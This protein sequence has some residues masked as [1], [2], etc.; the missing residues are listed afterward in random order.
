MVSWRFSDFISLPNYFFNLLNKNL[1]CTLEYDGESNLMGFKNSWLNCKMRTWHSWNIILMS[2]Y[3]WRGK[4]QV[5]WP[6]VLY[7]K[8]SQW[9]QRDWD[10]GVFLQPFELWILPQET[11]LKSVRNKGE[12]RRNAVTPNRAQIIAPKYTIGLIYFKLYNSAVRSTTF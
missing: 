4:I 11:K 2:R 6:T 9:D 3:K 12:K 8:T 7:P 1:S 5:A 10:Y